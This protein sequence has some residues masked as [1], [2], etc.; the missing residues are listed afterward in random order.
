MR[1]K[2]GLTLLSGMLT[3]GFLGACGNADDLDGDLDN[4][5]PI[6]EN[7]DPMNDDM[8]NDL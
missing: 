6:M 4:N 5:D 8:N 7:N 3:I 1:K 2:L